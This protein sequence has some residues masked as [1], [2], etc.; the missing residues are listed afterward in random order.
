MSIHPEALIRSGSSAYSQRPCCQVMDSDDTG[1]A[2]EAFNYYKVLC[3]QGYLAVRKH[4]ER[5]ILLVGPDR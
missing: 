4:A 5:I 1:M 2:S 3:I